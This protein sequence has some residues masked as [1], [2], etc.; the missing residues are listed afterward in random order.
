MS[1]KTQ[2]KFSHQKSIKLGSNRPD[3]ML[4]T[5]GLRKGTERPSDVSPKKLVL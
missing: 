1:V 5:Q 3:K 4:S 2:A